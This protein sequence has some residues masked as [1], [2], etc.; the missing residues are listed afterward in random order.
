VARNR[1]RAKERRARRPEHAGCVINPALDRAGLG[2]RWL[3][4]GHATESPRTLYFEIRCSFSLLLCGDHAILLH[5]HTPQ[6]L[7]SVGSCACFACFIRARSGNGVAYGAYF[8]RQAPGV[9]IAFTQPNLI[10]L[11]ELVDRGP[12][13]NLDEIVGPATESS[14]LRR[15]RRGR[16]H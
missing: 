5:R 2:G 7:G 15:G 12:F 14:F 9:G 16:G 6:T 1:K 10:Q 3:S 8:N 13:D 11:V 4:A